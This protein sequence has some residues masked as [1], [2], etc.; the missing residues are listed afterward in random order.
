[1]EANF[2]Q[3]FTRPTM[4]QVTIEMKRIMII[5][6]LLILSLIFPGCATAGDPRPYHPL[7]SMPE[8]PSP[9]EIARH[10][11]AKQK[12]IDNHPE[13]SQ[14]KKN[15]ISVNMWDYGFTKEEFKIAAGGDPDKIETGRFENGTDEM[16][17]Y[18]GVKWNDYFYFKD[19]VLIAQEKY[20]ARKI[21]Q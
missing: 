10:K 18:R 1:M 13:L 3:S 16:W 20:R 7:F 11:E 21:D 12:Y 6:H 8:N 5:P 2:P 15:L 14:R 17:F 4:R 19:G 9:E